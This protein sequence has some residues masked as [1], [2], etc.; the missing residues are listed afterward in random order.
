ML[1]LPSGQVLFDYGASQLYV[2]TP[3]GAP[4]AAWK[5]AITSINAG[6][7][8]NYTL[9]GTELNGLSAGT[10]YNG[11]GARRATATIRLWN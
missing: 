10:S 11:D 1:M 2:Y 6:V 9:T 8:N 3:D 4:D 7:G 5:P